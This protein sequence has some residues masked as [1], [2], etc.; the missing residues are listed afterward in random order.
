MPWHHFKQHV[1]TFTKVKPLVS[2]FNI[3]LLAYTYILTQTIYNKKNIFTSFRREVG[4]IS[5]SILFLLVWGLGCVRGASWRFQN[6][7]TCSTPV[8][9]R[10]NSSS[11]SC[12][13]SIVVGIPL[14]RL[15]K[16]QHMVNNTHTKTYL[17]SDDT[18]LLI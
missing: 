7:R 8:S 13:D 12:A 5:L 1:L 15:K 18:Q 9:L 4:E 11:P 10:I 17:S 6:H 2:L 3:K 14:Q 16:R